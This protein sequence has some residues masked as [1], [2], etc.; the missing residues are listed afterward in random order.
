M[1]KSDIFTTASSYLRPHLYNLVL[2]PTEHEIHKPKKP[3]HT[4]VS[5]I[6]INLF[7]NWPTLTSE[8]TKLV[9]MLNVAFRSKKVTQDSRHKPV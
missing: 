6:N 9:K 5:N 2:V 8:I 4:N 3:H 7:L 1:I